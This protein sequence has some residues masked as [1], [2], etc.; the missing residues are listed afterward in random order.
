MRAEGLDADGYIAREGSLS[1]VQPEFAPVVDHARTSITVAFQ[2]DCTHSVYLYG[3]I[4]R[5]TA[6]PRTSDL[7][8]LIA[9]H[10]DPTDLDRADADALA[11]EIDRAFPQINGAGIGLASTTKLLSDLERYDLGWF[12]ACLCTPLLGDDLARQLPRYRPTTLLARET[13]GDLD[14]AIRTWRRHPA[15]ELTT[16]QR[17]RLIRVAARKVVRT[18]LTLVM[19]E[20]GGWT[21]DLD[22]S[23]EVFGHYYPHRAVDMRWA[24]T[25]ARTP[26]TNPAVLD[27]LIDDLASW[28]AAEYTAIHGSKTPRT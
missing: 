15:T 23:A 8:V 7:D 21:S 26:T 2:T 5:G 14:Q 27:R 22:R 19:P 13:N 12:V 25:I 6:I 18:G 9:L 11:T 20:W 17:R 3:S 1:R 10:H 4:P 28:L 16:I 24:A